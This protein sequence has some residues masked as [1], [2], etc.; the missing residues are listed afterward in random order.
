L[1]LG[2]WD[3]SGYGKLGG[4]VGSIQASR[5]FYKLHRG[6]IAPGMFVCHKCD[7]PACVNPEHL[8][9]GDQ[10]ANLQDMKLK[11]RGRK[12]AGVQNSNARLG[13]AQVLEILGDRRSARLVAMDYGIC[14]QSVYAI[15]HGLTWNSLTK[16]ACS[17]KA[18]SREKPTCAT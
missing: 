9:L 7:T 4:N 3:V 16:I 8:F 11:G 10:A 15:R 6:P 13:E 17:W 2:K 12:A 5:E 14:M 18:S 1:W